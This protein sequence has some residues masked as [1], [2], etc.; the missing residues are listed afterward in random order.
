MSLNTFLL[1]NPMPPQLRRLTPF[2]LQLFQATVWTYTEFLESW[3]WL[4]GLLAIDAL[5]VGIETQGRYLA[6]KKSWTRK[7]VLVTDGESP[8]EIEDWEATTKKMDA[9]D[10]SLTIVYV[11]LVFKIFVD[12]LC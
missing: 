7:I 9:H 12:L 5:I 10:I 2:K 11:I 8:I 6:K 1:L 4:C 3:E